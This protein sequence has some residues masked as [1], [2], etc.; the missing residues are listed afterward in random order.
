MVG[1]ILNEQPSGDIWIERRAGEAGV[2]ADFDVLVL[3]GEDWRGIAYARLLE[4]ARTTH[5]LEE[6]ELRAAAGA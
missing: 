6:S 1:F 4:L 5:E 2:M 3:K